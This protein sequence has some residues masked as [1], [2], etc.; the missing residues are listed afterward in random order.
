MAHLQYVAVIGPEMKKVLQFIHIQKHGMA[1]AAVC[2]VK[3]GPKGFK[4]TRTY[5]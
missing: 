4:L 5:G 3:T 2:I 1:G